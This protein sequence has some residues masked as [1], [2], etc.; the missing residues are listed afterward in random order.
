LPD[1]VAIVGLGLIGG[2]LAR[3]LRAREVRVLGY[4]R[5]PATLAAAAAVGIEALRGLTDPALGEAG[6][7]VL[8]VPVTVAAELLPLVARQLG[9]GCVVTDVGSTKRSIAEAARRAGIGARFAGS[10]P[11]AGDHRSGWDA[12]REG[13]FSGARV[14]LC[15]SPDTGEAAL[16]AVRS[17]WRGVDARLEELGA[18]EH[19]RQLAWTSH[20]P[21][22]AASALAGALASAG[23]RP[24]QLGPGGRDATRLAASSPE[25][26]SAISRDNAEPI[27]AALSALTERLAAFQAALAADDPQAI[28]RFFELAHRWSRDVPPPP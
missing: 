25:V 3:D 10:H 28:R 2:S 27:A 4:D 24:D 15:P 5:E 12:S 26:W 23:W 16:A 17:L 13:L 21:Q 19:D 20:L 11:L 7:L 18:E 9:D 22:L 6:L 1:T 14:F 8:A